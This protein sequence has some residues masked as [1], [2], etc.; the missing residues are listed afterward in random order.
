MEEE[1][2]QHG[3]LYF[4]GGTIIASTK[5][6][7]AYFGVTPATLSNWMR[8]GC[9]RFKHGFW[10]I[11]AVTDWNAQKEGE[12]LAEVVRSDPEKMSPG[13]LKTHYD[14]ELKKEQLESTRLKNQIASG[15]YLSKTDVV[16]DLSKFFGL[17]KA[18][19]TGLGHEL[20]QMVAGYVDPDGARKADQRI[21]EQ[22]NDALGQLSVCGVYQAA[23]MNEP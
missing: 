21:N 17:F 15:E 20:G 18:S 4:A 22:I 19:V 7:A 23:D 16:N 2:E 1:K 14:A 8:S 5:Y 11:K 9:P 10:D 13:Q 12:R 3:D 6:A